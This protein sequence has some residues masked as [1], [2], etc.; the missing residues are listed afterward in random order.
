MAVEDSNLDVQIAA[1]RRV[2]DEGRTERSCIQTVRGRGYRF[3]APVARVASEA[4]A[5]MAIPTSGMPPLPD[6][7]SLARSVALNPQPM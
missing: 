2:V 1:L 4:R 5:S 3:I 6:K 7:P